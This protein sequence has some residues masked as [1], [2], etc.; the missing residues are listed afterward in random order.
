MR[1]GF[2]WCLL[3]G[4]LAFA[5]P[6]ARSETFINPVELAAQF[7]AA[8]KYRDEKREAVVAL[9]K[10]HIHS[11]SLRYQ[12]IDGDKHTLFNSLIERW[13]QNLN[14]PGVALSPLE[15]PIPSWADPLGAIESNPTLLKKNS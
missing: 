6:K 9:L 7:G 10:T 11:P 1:L 5:G 13:E 15:Y 3:I 14:T 4:S 12:F 8:A 2:L